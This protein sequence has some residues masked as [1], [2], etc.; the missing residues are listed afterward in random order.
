MKLAEVPVHKENQ[1]VLEYVEQLTDYLVLF[2]QEMKGMFFQLD[3]ER[4]MLLEFLME[5]SN[6]TPYKLFRE[7]HVF[8]TL[9]TYRT[10]NKNLSNKAVEIEIDALSSIFALVKELQI[11]LKKHQGQSDKDKRIRCH[12]EFLYCFNDFSVKQIVEHLI[13]MKVLD[14]FDED[15]NPLFE[16]HERRIYR[17]IKDFPSFTKPEDIAYRKKIMD[18]FL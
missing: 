14:E 8:K 17:Y 1:P 9:H 18:R 16:N 7:I 10:D 3:E 5:Y 2:H 4:A 11:Y 15:A 12:A 13:D 6:E